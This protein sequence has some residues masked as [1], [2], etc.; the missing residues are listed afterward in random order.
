MLLLVEG[1]KNLSDWYLKSIDLFLR[2]GHSHDRC[3]HWSKQ[4]YWLHSHHM[5]AFTSLGWTDELWSDQCLWL[6]T[7]TS[8]NLR[9]TGSVFPCNLCYRP[10]ICII[11]LL[12]AWSLCITGNQS[13]TVFGKLVPHAFSA[14]LA[15]AFAALSVNNIKNESLTQTTFPE[16]S[17]RVGPFAWLVLAQSNSCLVVAVQWIWWGSRH[18]Q[19]FLTMSCKSDHFKKAHKCILFMS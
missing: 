4:N 7:S 19:D 1:R 11:A 8:P 2:C 17:V 15:L 9:G 6:S 18:S 3:Y 5:N 14:R 12:A 13:N 16:I 10:Y